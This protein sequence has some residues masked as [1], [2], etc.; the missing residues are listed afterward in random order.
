[1]RL[2]GLKRYIKAVFLLHVPVGFA[3][4]NFEEASEAV[5]IR[6]RSKTHGDSQERCFVDPSLKLTPCFVDW[7]TLTW[8]I[9][10]ATM[11]YNKS[12]VQKIVN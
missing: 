11:T 8:H 3:S 5:A 4:A 9:K 6:E 10:A 2:T 1:M 7:S 12:N